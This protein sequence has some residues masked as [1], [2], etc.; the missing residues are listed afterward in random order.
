ML[1]RKQTIALSG[2]LLSTI[3]MM[4]TGCVLDQYFVPDKQNRTVQQVNYQESIQQPEV[5]VSSSPIEAECKDNIPVEESDCN[6][7]QIS[8]Q[9]LKNKNIHQTKRGVMHNLK[10]VRGKTIRIEERPNGF[11]FPNYPGKVIVLEMFGKD[12]PH[13]IKEIPIIKNIKKR[14]R[15]K[16]EVIAIQSQGRMGQRVARNYINKYRI[17][18]PIIEGEDATNLQYFVQST[19]GWTGILPYMLVIK[20][21]ITEFSYPGAVSYQ[22]L[23]S[24]IDS[25]F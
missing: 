8:P 9:Q 15:G 11:V 7:G 1:K 24:D 25:L 18:Y 12:C 21:G 23:K 20:N 19:Y 17:N 6:R 14:Y 3:L 13:C 5:I 22:E 10:S 4:N 2:V 16:L